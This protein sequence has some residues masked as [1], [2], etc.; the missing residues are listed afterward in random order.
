MQGL[1]LGVEGSGLRVSK[2]GKLQDKGNVAPP[3]LVGAWSMAFLL[4]QH[5]EY[6]YRNVNGGG[7]YY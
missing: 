2:M 4:R 5:V 6:Y 3:I 7:L 1:S